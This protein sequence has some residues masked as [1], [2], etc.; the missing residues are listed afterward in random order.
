MLSSGTMV[1]IDYCISSFLTFR[2]VI[3]ENKIFKKGIMRPLYPLPEI[4][5]KIRTADDI[6]AAIQEVFSSTVDEQAGIMLSGGM[7]SAVLASYLP[8]GTK[9]YTLECQAAGATQ[10]TNKARYFAEKCGLD[11]RIVKISWEDYE[12]Y[13]PLCMKLKGAPLHSIE[14]MICKAAFQAKSDGCTKLIFGDP[15]DIKFGGMD[16]LLAQD[17]TEDEFKKRYT[18]VE[19]SRVVKRPID[20]REPF[21]KYAQKGFYDAHGFINDFFLTEAH[22]SYSNPCKIAG[23]EYVTPYV[24]MSLDGPI[25]LQRIRRGES[26]YLIRELFAKR[27]PGMAPAT[28]LAMPRAVGFWLKDWE[29]PQRAEFLPDCIEG[30]TGDQIWYVYVL[31]WFLNL[32][33]NN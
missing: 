33:E 1:D 10:E 20:T 6:C 31:E 26:K 32:I 18:F 21:A 9:A 3:D 11:H 19:P 24:F 12:K 17:W 28:K 7:D 15:A 16:G 30:L 2:F 14:P 22:N 23:V 25:D 13:A 4:R 5:F 8:A 29:G 27:Y